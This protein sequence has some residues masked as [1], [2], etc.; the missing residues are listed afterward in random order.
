M[1]PFSDSSKTWSFYHTS[2]SLPWLELSQDI[3]YYLRLLWR[4]LFPWLPFQFTCH[5]YRALF[6]SWT[7]DGALPCP[8]TESGP[9]VATTFLLLGPELLWC[10]WGSQVMFCGNLHLSEAWWWGTHWAVYKCHSG[11]F[12][13]LLT[14]QILWEHTTGLILWGKINYQ[15]PQ[16]PYYWWC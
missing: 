2:L 10:V 13:M 5:L 7:Y 11:S 1:I 12:H 9:Y 4:V 6:H 16:N 3:L 14:P 15:A 8:A